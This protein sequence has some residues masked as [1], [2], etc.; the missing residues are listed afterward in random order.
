[1]RVWVGKRPRTLAR[2]YLWKVR[3]ETEKTAFWRPKG[4]G[5][6]LA[7]TTILKA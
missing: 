2:M 5:V 7:R 6:S 4:T 3:L 1:M